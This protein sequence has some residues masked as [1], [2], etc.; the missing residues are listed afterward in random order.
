MREII[1]N[2]KLEIVASNQYRMFIAKFLYV[3]WKKREGLSA[4][5]RET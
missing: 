2:V 3:V 4:V 1:K 5:F